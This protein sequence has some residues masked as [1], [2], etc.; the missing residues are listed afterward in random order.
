MGAVWVQSSGQ[1]TSSGKAKRSIGAGQK[2]KSGTVFSSTCPSLS[3]SLS[4]PVFCCSSIS[5]LF[6]SFFPFIPSAFTPHSLPPFCQHPTHSSPTAPA[7][8]PQ[9]PQRPQHHSSHHHRP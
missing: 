9:H 7:Q 8:H 4:L 1:S 2:V 6:N 5:L 3:P